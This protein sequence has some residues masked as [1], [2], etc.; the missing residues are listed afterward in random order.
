[1]FGSI[2]N[3]FLALPNKAVVPL[4]LFAG[5]GLGLGIYTIYM[6]RAWSYLGNDPAACVNCHVMAPAYAAWS[7]SSHRGWATCKDCHVP[8]ANLLAGYWF[9]AMDGIYH[10]AVFTLGKE[11]PAPRP[12]MASWRVIQGN[13]V[14]CHK[15][16]N[17]ALAGAGRASFSDIE[18]GRAKPCWDCHR[19][20][21]HGQVS[22][23]A[24]APHAIAPLPDSPVPQWLKQLMD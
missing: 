24:S 17:T 1:M 3:A 22:G 8:Q 18:H 12:R 14:R 10:G 9:E 20:T 7:R 21:P 15:Q 13:C 11:S 23:L 6:S 19:N 4:V 2:K 5:I 16:L